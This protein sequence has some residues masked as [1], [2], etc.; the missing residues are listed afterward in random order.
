MEKFLAKTKKMFNRKERKVMRK[1][2][3][4]TNLNKQVYAL[5]ALMLLL[6]ACMAPKD[7]R[8]SRKRMHQTEPVV[9]ET[10]YN[11]RG[12]ALSV[13]FQAG[14]SFN[15]P[16]MAIWLEDTL[17][18]YLQTLYVAQSIAS[19]VF[20]HGDP[21]T[22]RWQP[23]PRRRPAA[24]PYWGHQRG[25]QASDGL[26][27][28][29]EADPLPDAITGPTPKGDFVLN[30]HAPASNDQT[31]RLLFE[32]NQSWDWNRYWTNNKFP[33]DSAYITSSQP[34]VV[35]EATIDLNSSISEYTLYPIGHSHWSGKSG[36]LFTDLSTLTT[37]LD[38]AS[39]IKV[40]VSP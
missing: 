14:K 15:H 38:I 32:I 34:A 39:E 28:P 24:L 33:G 20:R 40:R 23:G 5:T 26:Y 12:M 13:H 16:L 3:N 25:I 1:G 37:A 21:S 8:D 9:I 17:G 36:E 30:T 6:S 29:E 4:R 22:G 11:G 7:A 10:A 2:M 31:V 35:Y 27:L 18:N 19:G